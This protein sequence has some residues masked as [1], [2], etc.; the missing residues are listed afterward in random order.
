VRQYVVGLVLIV[1]GGTIVIGA[2]SGNLAPMIAAL[3]DTGDL[4]GGPGGTPTGSS[5]KGAGASQPTVGSGAG[6]PPSIG[7]TPSQFA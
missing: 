2:I 7:G 1:I 6:V 5:P 3:F 4:Q